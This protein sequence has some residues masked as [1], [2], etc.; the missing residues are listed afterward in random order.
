MEQ[1]KLCLR[2]PC[3]AIRGAQAEN[4]KF[5]STCTEEDWRVCKLTEGG[6][7]VEAKQ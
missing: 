5:K 2:F 7:K 6:N 1:T 3:P 4:Y